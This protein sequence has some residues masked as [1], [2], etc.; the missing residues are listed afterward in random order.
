MIQSPIPPS[1]GCHG[2]GPRVQGDP[3]GEPHPSHEAVQ[4]GTNSF[5]ALGFILRV[6]KMGGSHTFP[7]GFRDIRGHRRWNTCCVEGAPSSPAFVTMVEI[8]RAGPVWSCAIQGQNQG[9]CGRHSQ[10]TQSERVACQALPTGGGVPPLRVR[11]GSPRLRGGPE[12]AGVLWGAG[13]HGGRLGC[14]GL[15]RGRCPSTC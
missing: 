1:P 11:N 6:Y 12:G 10:Q 3:Q 14:V 2:A 5:S 9:L 7:A 4:L 13:G 8:A 15:R